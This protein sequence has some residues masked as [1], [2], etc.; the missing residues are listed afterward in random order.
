MENSDLAFFLVSLN[1]AALL[2]GPELTALRISGS[3]DPVVGSRGKVVS[4]PDGDLWVFV[5]GARW[6][7]RCAQGDEPLELGTEIKV[8]G[9]DR[10][11]L[12][13]E[14]T[15]ADPSSPDA[16]TGLGRIALVRRFGLLLWMIAFGLSWFAF[17]SIFPAALS[18]PVLA[19]LFLLPVALLD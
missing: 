18:V 17:G 9:I 14:P 8:L 16:A 7:A 15:A 5:H 12:S 1:S 2:V 4:S 3:D 13:V 10:L 11:R 6:R 19:A